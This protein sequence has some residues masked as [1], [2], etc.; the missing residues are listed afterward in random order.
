MKLFLFLILSRDEILVAFAQLLIFC[1]TLAIYVLLWVKLVWKITSGAVA[2]ALTPPK[3]WAIRK[4][5]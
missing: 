2:G 5:T 4:V 1:D 3:F